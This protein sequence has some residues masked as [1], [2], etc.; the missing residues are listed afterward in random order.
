MQF[1]CSMFLLGIIATK[2]VHSFYLLKVEGGGGG[3]VHVVWSRL[4]KKAE[5]K[6]KEICTELE[7]DQEEETIELCDNNEEG[8]FGALDESC[9][10]I[11]SGFMTPGNRWLAGPVRFDPTIKDIRPQPKVRTPAGGDSAAAAAEAVRRALDE[12]SQM[13]ERR[14]ERN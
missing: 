2:T 6:L 11:V 4:K 7:Q 13:H 5:K 14:E 10:S 1:V 8:E 12:T 3:E 9:D